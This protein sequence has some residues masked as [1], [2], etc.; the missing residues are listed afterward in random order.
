M[1]EVYVDGHCYICDGLDAVREVLGWYAHL[2]TRCIF[3]CLNPQNVTT[4]HSGNPATVLAQ[5]DNERNRSC[6]RCM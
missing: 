5:L 6:Q 1:I 2:E 3:D 4:T